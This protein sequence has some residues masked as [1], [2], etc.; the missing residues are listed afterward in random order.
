LEIIM[1]ESVL[2]ITA[3]LTNVAEL[4]MEIAPEQMTAEERSILQDRLPTWALSVAA[5]NASLQSL[6]AALTGLEDKQGG[7]R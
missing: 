6:E 3:K 1:A 4:I 7:G 5:I 2:T